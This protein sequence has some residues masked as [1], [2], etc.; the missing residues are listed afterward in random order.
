MM[1][2]GGRGRRGGRISRNPFRRN[3]QDESE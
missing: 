3:N 2:L 1:T